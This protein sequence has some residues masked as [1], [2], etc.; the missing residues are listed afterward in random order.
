MNAMRLFAS[1]LN[2]ILLIMTPGVNQPLPFSENPGIIAQK[3][4]KN[5][6]LRAWIAT[7]LFFMAIPGTLLGFSD[8]MAIS[9]HH[10]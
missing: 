10:A 4:H 2:L 5:L 1:W 7:G 8:L 6:M 3:R 9:T